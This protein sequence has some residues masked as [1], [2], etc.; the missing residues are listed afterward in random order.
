MELPKRYDPQQTELWARDLWER[1]GIYDFDSAGPGLVRAVDTPPATVSGDLHLGHT[2]S[3]SQADFMARYWRMRGYRVFYPMGF[4]DNGL[5]TERLVE[6]ERDG[7]GGDV[8][9]GEF[10]EACQAAS[11]RYRPEYE[12]LWRRLALSVDWRHSYRTSDRRSQRIAQWSF[13]DLHSKGRV[14]RSKSPSIWCPECGTAVA[15][16]ELEELER[17]SEYVFLRFEVGDWPLPI[18]T[19][20]PELLPACVAVFVHP[21]D[22]RYQGLAGKEATVPGTGKRVPILEDAGADP[23][24]GTGAVMCC[25]FGDAADVDWWR[26]HSLPAVEILGQDGLLTSAAGDTAGLSVK[27]ARARTVEQLEAAG[28]LL[29]REP[30]VQTVRVHDRC[31]TPVEHLLTDQWFVRVL[32]I[33]E[34]LRSIGDRISWHPTHMRGVYEKWV[35]NLRWDW[36]ISRQR[37]FGV[38]FPVWYCG[39]CGQPTVAEVDGLPVDPR[40]ERPGERCACGGES[41]VP[42]PDVMDTWATSSLTPQIAGGWLQDENLYG[43]VFPMTLRP[44]AH[45][46]IRTWA[47]YTIVKSHLHFGEVP[48]ESIAISGWGLAPEGAGK[49][50]KR[51]GGGPAS[52]DEVMDRYSPD[53][54]RY[55]ASCTGFG[56]DSIINEEKMQAGHRLT[57][58]LWNVARFSQRFLEAIPPAGGMEPRLPSDRWLLSRLQRVVSLA[59]EAFDRYE[60]AAA[61]SAVEAFFWH[62][63]ADNYLELAKKRLYTDGD[64][65]QA[66]AQSVLHQAVAAVV[67]LL[68]PFLPYT[69]EAVYQALFAEEEECPSVHRARW[70][71]AD[72]GLVDEEAEGTGEELLAIATA[73]RRYKTE[74]ELRLGAE[75]PKLVLATPS[76]ALRQALE[77]SRP[78]LVSVTRARVLEVVAELPEGCEVLPAEGAVRV[79]VC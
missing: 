24:K 45:E 35:D 46:I 11:R 36:C 75:V 10:V 16:A 5:P 23:E 7:E 41:W 37:R 22:S 63:L 78:D 39:R 21:E 4:D 62:D 42:E 72:G 58:K 18:A 38:P 13:V 8:S 56:R 59:T 19:T 50:S 54:V 49:I 67:K 1:L 79:A 29:G 17:P 32:D 28:L 27:D 64:S 51:K 69:A 44:Q 43:Q 47:F 65:G 74:R 76:E 9:R 71:E 14:Y 25:T 15:Q 55:W 33:K 20:R 52:P 77:E 61:R 30:T 60:Y 48:W 2:Y 34:E 57:V 3:Y 68:A 40:E 70:P 6:R 73:V 53:A 31:D 12:R 66:S 26:S